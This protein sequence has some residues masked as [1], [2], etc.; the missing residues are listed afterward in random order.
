MKEYK[1]RLS[2][3]AIFNEEDR[4]DM[5]EKSGNK[6][7][8]QQL[9][10]I[11]KS[12]IDKQKYN[13]EV[14]NIN[15]NLCKLTVQLCVEWNDDDAADISLR[16]ME[17]YFKQ[18]LIDDLF[19]K[20][21]AMFCNLKH[22][23]PEIKINGLATSYNAM[24]IQFNFDIKQLDYTKIDK[25]PNIEHEFTTE[26]NQHLDKDKY[27]VLGVQ[28]T[29]NKIMVFICVKLSGNKISNGEDELKSAEIYV[30]ENLN[31]VQIAKSIA[32]KFCGNE[33]K[34]KIPSMIITGKY[35]IN[36]IHK[37]Q[38]NK[39]EENM[40]TKAC[41]YQQSVVDKLTPLHCMKFDDIKNM[42][43]S[44]I[45]KDEKYISHCLEIMRIIKRKNIHGL[46]LLEENKKQVNI[47][48]YIT[49]CM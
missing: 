16:R 46:F 29:D 9:S 17:F 47:K 2:M 5:F 20:Q 23:R 42:I 36:E 27:D 6:N 33:N 39:F 37:Q 14:I 10:N 12:V 28:I 3:E 31:N 26:F 24:K 41:E 30:Y 43:C 38:I 18:Q 21:V 8:E 25:Y 34:D 13:V 48:T 40:R 11:M 45:L 1:S 35:E 19:T 44:W 15:V 49:A 7:Y 4:I 32:D 22:L